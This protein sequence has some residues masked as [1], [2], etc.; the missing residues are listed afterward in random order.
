MK[1]PAIL[2]QRAKV[3]LVFDP[4]LEADSTAR[5]AVVEI[6]LTDGTRLKE[7]VKAVRGTPDNPMTR[8]EVV[9]KARDLIAPVLGA[10]KTSRLIETVLNLENVKNLGEL[11]PLLQL[12]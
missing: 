1:D 12:S 2:K 4:A 9:T 11:R 3:Q 5:Q 8:D 10:A 7:F 6:T